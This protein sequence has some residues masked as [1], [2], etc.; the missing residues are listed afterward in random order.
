MITFLAIIL[1]LTPSIIFLLASHPLILIGQV[2]ITTIIIAWSLAQILRNS[3]IRFILILI[4]LGGLLIIFVYLS[5]LVPNEILKI[6]PRII[7]FPLIIILLNP[8]ILKKE[9]FFLKKI[10]LFSSLNLNMFIPLILYLLIIILTVT[11][12]FTL[13]IKRPAKQ[14]IN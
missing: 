6:K 12:F 11:I 2:V 9:I 4:C 3:W 8:I 5:S 10:F 1:F 13:L 7:F 14:E